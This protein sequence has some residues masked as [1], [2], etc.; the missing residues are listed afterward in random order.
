MYTPISRNHFLKVANGKSDHATLSKANARN[1]T[2]AEFCLTKLPHWN[3]RETRI[4]NA[5]RV[6]SEKIVRSS[7]F[8]SSKAWLATP[9]GKPKPHCRR[10]RSEKE[11]P[12][13]WHPQG[14]RGLGLPGRVEAEKAQEE[15]N[16]EQ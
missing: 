10:P 11:Q 5:A 2:R 7:G 8:P 14:R 6:R 12:N 16:P 15:N 4:A 3:E 1:K 13:H 9:I